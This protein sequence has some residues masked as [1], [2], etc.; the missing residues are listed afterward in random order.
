MQ[1][2]LKVLREEILIVSAHGEGS[3]VHSHPV[4]RASSPGG[5]ADL[6]FVPAEVLDGSQAFE[7]LPAEMSSEQVSS[8]VQESPG[9]Y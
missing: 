4:E 2:S 6:L 9:P 1:S 7:N 5:E 8:L 3:W